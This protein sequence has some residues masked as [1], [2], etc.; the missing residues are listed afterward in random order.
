MRRS[1]IYG[2]SP[3]DLSHCIQVELRLA[4][5]R[6]AAAYSLCERQPDHRPT[7]ALR[8]HLWRACVKALREAEQ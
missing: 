3:A 6:G 7:M 1:Y 4:D 2:V 5:G 8:H